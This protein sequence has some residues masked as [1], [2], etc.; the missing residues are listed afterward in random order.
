MLLT[1]SDN[2]FGK[3]TDSFSYRCMNRGGRGS[4]IMKNRKG[5]RTIIAYPVTDQD[6]VIAATDGGQVIRFR[7]KDISVSSRT[8][9]GV[10][11]V[12]MPENEKIVSVTVLP[13]QDLDDHDD[14]DENQIVT[15]N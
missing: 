9:S 2:G 15:E 7:A 1:M 10:I 13:N 3:R 11:I 14:I 6:D 5:G 4:I 12:R 8:A